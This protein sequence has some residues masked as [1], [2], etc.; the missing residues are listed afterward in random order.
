VQVEPHTNTRREEGAVRLPYLEP[1]P[2]TACEARD[3]QNRLRTMVRLDMDEPFEPQTV[4]GLDVAYCAASDRLAA[5]VV[6]LDTQT[7]EVVEEV[8]ALGV[9][10][11]DYVPGLLAFRELPPLV[12]ALQDLTITPDLLVCDGYGIAHPRRF[13]LACHVGVLTDRPTIGV[14][15]NP[16]TG[17]YR[18]PGIERG[19]WSDLH[20]DGETL[21]RVLRT[22]RGVKPVFVSVGH[23]MSIERAAELVVVLCLRYRLPETTRLADQLS[24]RRLRQP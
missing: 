1:W 3:I 15:K 8:T 22:Q 4:A 16:F 10:T 24:R 13:G 9:A 18:T 7:L 20:E 14:A 6:V 19:S 23:R 12:A 2:E 17:E 11:F 21:G 5:A